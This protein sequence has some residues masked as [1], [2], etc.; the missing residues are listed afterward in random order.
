[1]GIGFGDVEDEVCIVLHAVVAV[2]G[3]SHEVG[4][5]GF[6]F[7][8]IAQGFLIEFL[9][10]QYAHHQGARFNQAD[11][12]VL[13]LS[14]GV[15]LGVDVADFLH[16]QAALQADGIVQPSADEEDILCGD[17]LGGK[18]LNPRLVLQ[19]PLHF[20]GQGF[21]L[22]DQGGGLIVRQLPAVLGEGNGQCVDGQQLGAVGLGGCH[23]DFRTGQSI[24]DVVR[25]PGNGGAHDVDDGQGFGSLLLGLAQGGQRISGFTGL[26][27]DNHQSVFRHKGVPIAE[28][29]GKLHP[30]GNFCQILQHILGGHAHVVGRAAAD[31]PYLSEG[32]DSIPGQP[33]FFQINGAIRADGAQSVLH[34][35]GLLVDFLH[36]EVLIAAFFGG[37]R[38]PQDLHR[39]FGNFVPVQIEEGDAL[40]GQA[41]KLQIAQIVHRAGVFQNGGHIRGKV[42]FPVLGAENHGA[43]LSGGVNLPGVVPEQHGQSIGAADADHGVIDGIHRGVGVF[44][45]VVID[46]LHSHFRIGG[47]VEGI[48]LAQ[49]LF[50][51]LLIVFDNA[52]VNGDHI[53]VVRAVGM[54]VFLAGFAMGGPT[55]VADAAVSRQRA[56]AVRFFLQC[57]QPPL[58]L[59]NLHRR[60]SI[61]HGQTGRVIAPI[62]QL[63]KAVQQN[64]RGR[65][66]PCK[67][68]DSAHR[69]HLQ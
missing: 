19:Q 3:Q 16:F 54:G 6:A 22:P 32:G 58:G 52:V 12:A 29:R 38:I 20:S 65:M 60:R 63:G 33:G 59:D 39:L 49:E 57:F 4:T 40:G 43:V 13:Q 66:L 64:R 15:G 30:D 41:G 7:Q 2:G 69:C 50:P 47:G 17:L 56:A 62:F 34:R 27:D 26:A 24:E 9:L 48:A 36:H 11:G 35:L 14:G 18:P 10:G 31:N 68:N 51:Q 55:G 21:Q 28:F 46:E 25:L 67:T 1:M 37:F 44:F 23:G 8:K 42:L 5:S 45:I 61:P 53:A